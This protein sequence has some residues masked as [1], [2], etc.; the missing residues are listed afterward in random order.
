MANRLIINNDHAGARMAG[1]VTFV[2]DGN[3]A[4]GG[5]VSSKHALLVVGKV[6]I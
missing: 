3:D 4:A 6:F 1:S 2:M 5:F